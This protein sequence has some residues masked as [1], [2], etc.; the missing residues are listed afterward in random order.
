MR[1][2]LHVAPPAKKLHVLQSILCLC[3]GAVGQQ[4]LSPS[5]D[6]AAAVD[7]SQETLIPPEAAQPKQLHLLFHQLFL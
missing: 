2:K 5:G 7:A 4:R 1:R 3:H 6:L